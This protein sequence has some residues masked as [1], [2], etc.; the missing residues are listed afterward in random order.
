MDTW[1]IAGWVGSALVVV[2]L[3]QHRVLRFRVLNLVACAVLVAFNTALQV[4]PMAALNLLLVVVNTWFVARLVR[5]MSDSAAF[6]V[7][8][9]QHDDSY[10]AHVLEVHAADIARFQ[11]DFDPSTLGQTSGCVIYLVQ[12]ADET[13]GVVVLEIQGD[14]AE[15]RLDYV[16][17]KY[18]DFSPG[19]F[20]WRR[21]G[22]LATKGVRHVITS[23]RMVNAYYGNVG[24]RR[25]GDSWVLDA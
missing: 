15:V 10:L 25:E 3:L 4:W 2:S 22:M 18:R 23:P 20:V 19:E 16:T 24:F 6:E 1:D 11:P 12:K 14:T 21:S 17:P 13:V 9:V 5:E 8:P 7:F